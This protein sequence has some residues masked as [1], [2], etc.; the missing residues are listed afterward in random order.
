[1]KRDKLL[2]HHCMNFEDISYA[3]FKADPSKSDPEWIN[4]TKWIAKEIGFWPLFFSV[5]DD[6]D[7]YIKTGYD[8]NW[9]RKIGHDPK[10]GP[11]LVKAGKSPNLVMFS[12]NHVD[13]V[14]MDHNIFFQ[15]LILAGD[16]EIKLGIVQRRWLFKPRWSRKKWLRLAKEDPYLGV[17]LVAPGMD[18]RAANRI[19]VRNKKT[20]R[21]LK[22]MGF[23]NVVV[24]RIPVSK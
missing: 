23:S 20:Q 8:F 17:T 22:K 12:F 6:Y 3:A 4:S 2:Y 1:M 9:K 15:Y 13:G 11:I 14:F 16:R 10:V 7:T 18:P 5:G 21:A 24:H 19:W